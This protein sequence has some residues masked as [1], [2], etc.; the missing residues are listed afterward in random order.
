MTVFA[1]CELAE[2]FW[3]DESLQRTTNAQFFSV[4][5][6]PWVE[7]KR[8]GPQPRGPGVVPGAKHPRSDR[9]CGSL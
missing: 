8:Q 7:G 3:N 6:K 5:R 9:G 4:W 2:Q 1:L